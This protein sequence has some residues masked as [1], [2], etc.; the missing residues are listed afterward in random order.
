M[1]LEVTTPNPTWDAEAHAA[2]VEALAG[3]SDATVHVW[4]ADWCGD[5]RRELPD[6]FAAVEAAGVRDRVTVHAVDEDKD[7][8]L[9]DAYDVTHIPTVVVERDGETVARFEERATLP[10]PRAIAEELR[11]DSEV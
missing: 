9:T 11:D 4:A 7:G 8:D 10:A 3:L 5:C 6:L 2:T 1:T